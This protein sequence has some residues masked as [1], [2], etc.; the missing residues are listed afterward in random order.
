[1]LEGG[2][3]FTVA[4][5]DVDELVVELQAARK[6]SRPRA[7]P[8]AKRAERFKKLLRL[9][10]DPKLGSVPMKRTSLKKDARLLLFVQRRRREIGKARLTFTLFSLPAY[11]KKTLVD[12]NNELMYAACLLFVGGSRIEFGSNTNQA[13][14]RA[15]RALW[16]RAR[17]GVGLREANEVIV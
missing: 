17:Q 12:V 2:R 3:E 16:A 6:A 1:L 14:R 9:N 15:T 8:P 10:E 13:P 7:P 11:L 4:V 5:T